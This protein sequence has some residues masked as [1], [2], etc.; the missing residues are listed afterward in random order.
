MKKFLTKLDWYFDYYIVWILYNGNNSDKYVDYMIKKWI[1]D[2]T[3]SNIYKTHVR[4]HI[5]NY[6]RV[7]DKSISV[8]QKLCN[9]NDSIIDV[10][11]ATGETL[12]RLHDAGFNNFNNVN[13]FNSNKMAQLC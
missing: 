10:G 1:F 11:C 2:E 13:Y 6:D 7:I 8:C 5:P 3:V 9:K 4:Q 12:Q